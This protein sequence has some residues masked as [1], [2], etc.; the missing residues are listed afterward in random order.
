MDESLSRN[1]HVNYLI[2]KV[3]KRIGILGCTRRS[4]SMHTVTII[5]KSFILPVIDYCNTVWSCCGCVN[6][7]NVEKIQ[8][9]AARIIMHMESS[10]DV[11]A[12]LNYDTLG[13]R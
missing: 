7:D 13:L 11:L 10:D 1:V 4:I 12:H 2:S 3:S 9:C 5:Y 8:R 6:A